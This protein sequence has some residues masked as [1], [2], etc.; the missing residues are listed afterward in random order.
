MVGASGRTMELTG[1]RGGGEGPYGPFSQSCFFRGGPCV[2]RLGRAPPRLAKRYCRLHGS[3]VSAKSLNLRN[4]QKCI[5]NCTKG[6]PW[7]R[8]KRTLRVP[9]LTGFIALWRCAPK[10]RTNAPNCVRSV[11][12]KC[13]GRTETTNKQQ[14]IHKH[15]QAQLPNPQNDG[16]GPGVW[17]FLRSTKNHQEDALQKMAG[18]PPSYEQHLKFKKSKQRVHSCEAP[19]IFKKTPFKKWRAFPP[20]KNIWKS[21][22][23]GRVRTSPPTFLPP[24]HIP[25]VDTRSTQHED[26]YPGVF[27]SVQCTK[28]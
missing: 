2:K 12:A 10:R 21:R 18:I 13:C 11:Q 27:A 4:G 5:R 14:K 22:K 7:M 26:D 9:W 15:T 23:P 28:K 6:E 24:F 3:T 1:G 25:K 20:K 16:Q 17:A 19:K 8:A